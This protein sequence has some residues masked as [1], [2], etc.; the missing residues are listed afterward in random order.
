MTHVT[1]PFA[2]YTGC[3][4]DFILVDNRGCCFP[5]PEQQWVIQLCNRRLGVGADGVILLENSS[6]ADYRMRIFNSDGSEAAMCGNG[7]RCLM[8]FIHRLHSNVTC[9]SIE[10]GA[11]V[12]TLSV[13]SNGSICASVGHPHSIQWNITLPTQLPYQSAHFLNTGVPHLVLFVEDVDC[14]DL[15][16]VAP[17]L[18]HHAQFG[19]NGTNVN[20]ASLSSTRIRYRTW[21]RGVEGETLACGTGA[22]AIAIAAHRQFDMPSPITLQ[23]SSEQHLH[24]AFKYVHNA[25]SDII[26]SGPA[27][28]LF[29]GI[30]TRIRCPDS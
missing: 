3:G 10:T 30:Y 29:D 4:N 28:H 6:Y 18:R 5:L 24:I 1:L 17:P 16:H 27:D 23:T 20:I 15:A 19:P 22:I 12:L 14:I 13:A 25:W 21:E 2:K 26:M 8:R 7:I 11:G 9:A